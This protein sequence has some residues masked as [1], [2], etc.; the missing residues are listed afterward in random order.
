MSATAVWTAPPTWPIPR[1]WDD[2]RCFILCGGES[3][4]EQRS[5][6]PRLKGRWIVVKEGVLLRPDADVMFVGGERSPDI[7]LP[8]VPKFKGKYVIVRGRFNPELPT[9]WKRV[10]RSKD[11][12]HLC[13]LRD[14]VCGYDSGTSAINAAYHL[15]AKEIVMI[16]Y[17]MRGHRWFNGEWKHP[18]PTIPE[19]T[20]LQH[21]EPLNALA[22]DCEAK[23]LKVWNASPISRAKCFEYRALETFL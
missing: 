1:E 10:T 21:L 13:Q 2:E 17:D 12:T 3:V 20:H 23:G 4:R 6:I 7:A 5:L 18:R 15:G 11:H 14:H 22:K 9:T 8:L 19:A 16:G